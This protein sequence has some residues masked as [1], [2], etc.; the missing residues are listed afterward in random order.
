PS[1]SLIGAPLLRRNQVKLAERLLIKQC[2]F[3]A[4]SAAP[5]FVTT[6]NPNE[7]AWPD[8]F[9][10]GIVPVQIGAT[11]DDH[12]HIRRM[13]VHPRIESRTEF[14]KPPERSLG[15]IAPD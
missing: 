13:R 12:E 7:V 4:I 10:T 8:T 3:L 6:R 5:V 9:G 1:G 11:Q 2:P 15:G 14:R